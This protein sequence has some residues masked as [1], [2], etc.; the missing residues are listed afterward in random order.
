[1]VVV[2][3]IDIPEVRENLDSLI[4]TLKKEAGHTRVIGISAATGERVKEVMQRVRKLV[5]SMPQQNI[6]ELFTDEEERVSFEDEI[7]DSFEV[8][9]DENF[10]G[11]FRV[12]GEK[13]ER[14]VAMTNWDYYEAV[15]RFQRI[16]EA[17]GIN[18][19]LKEAGAREG[20]LV[21]TPDTVV[22]VVP[23]TTVE[24]E[25]TTSET[26]TV[27][28]GDFSVFGDVVVEPLLSLTI[29]PGGTLLGAVKNEMA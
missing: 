21:M 15:Q 4:E 16:L 11:Q 3:K 1:V 13:I 19:A 29:P 28:V 9:T 27:S 23:T 8:F 18:D 24:G 17:E 25:E 22:G 26:T 2:N 14:I 6:L 7:D 5:D 12:V 10:P 20:D